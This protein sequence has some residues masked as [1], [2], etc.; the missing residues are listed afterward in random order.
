MR[1]IHM[2]LEDDDEESLRLRISQPLTRAPL[3]M[4]PDPGEPEIEEDNAEIDLTR[5]RTKNSMT[6]SLRNSLRNSLRKGHKFSSS[7]HSAGLSGDCTYAVFNDDS[8]VSVFR[9]GD[10]RRPPASLGFSR[11]FTQKYQ[12]RKHN[13][14]IRGVASSRLYI[15][16]VTNKS[17]LVFKIMDPATAMYTLPHLKWDP[18]GLACHESETHLVVFSGQC[19][20]NTTTG[21]YCGQIGVYR[22]RKEGQA[23]ELPSFVLNVPANDYP[24]RL[25]FHADSRILTCITRLQNKLLMWKLNDDFLSVWG[26]CEFQKNDYTAVSARL[27]T[28]PADRY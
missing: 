1:I 28:A 27:A 20:R 16:I 6:F 9:L 8:E 21:D 26:P 14:C 3:I 12:Q 2:H 11:V 17:L 4:S 15:V 5:S 22:Y 7:Y 18:S 25:S 13:E 23:R 24:K 19:Q 10:L